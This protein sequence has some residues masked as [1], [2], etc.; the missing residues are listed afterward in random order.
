LQLALFV[1]EFR[2][3]CGQTVEIRI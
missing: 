2:K 1:K 3:I